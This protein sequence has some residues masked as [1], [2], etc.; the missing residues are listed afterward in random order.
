M[1][2]KSFKTVTVLE[3]AKMFDLS[4][5]AIYIAAYKGRIFSQKCPKNRKVM[6]KVAD[7]EAYQKSRW[8]RKKRDTVFDQSKGIYSITKTA[9][10]LGISESRIYREVNSGLLKAHK[11]GKFWAIHIDDIQIY[12][13]KYLT[14]R[15][16]EAI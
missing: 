14:R 10:L 2:M 16:K 7:L 12:Q 11:K 8:L 9:D 13:E 3:A 1:K 5:Q 4:P 6:I 15:E